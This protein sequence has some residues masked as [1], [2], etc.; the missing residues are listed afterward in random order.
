ME[1]VVIITD[2]LLDKAFNQCQLTLSVRH[3]KL[4]KRSIVML[5]YSRLYV[6][7]D[8]STRLEMLIRALSGNNAQMFV[9]WVWL[10]CAVTDRLSA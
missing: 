2:P 6:L 1:N 3:V 7:K 8:H 4:V 5:N 10:L 9:I